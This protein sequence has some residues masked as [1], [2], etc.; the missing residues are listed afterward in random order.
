MLLLA[1][2][3]QSATLQTVHWTESNVSVLNFQA[4]K[5][6]PKTFWK[7]ISDS[8]IHRINFP[9]V[10]AGKVSRKASLE[11]R[12]RPLL[13]KWDC[14]EVTQ[15]VALA[16]VATG[17]WERETMNFGDWKPCF[18]A[19]R[20]AISVDRDSKRG[21]CATS[22]SLDAMSDE[23]LQ[24]MAAK[25][26]KPY[27]Q[28]KEAIVARRIRYEVDCLRAF[29]DADP[30]RK[31]K[32]NFKK[33]LRVLRYLASIYK[34]TGQGFSEIT[35]GDSD[36]NLAVIIFTYRE[37]LKKGEIILTAETLENTPKVRRV[38]LKSLSEIAVPFKSIV[39]EIREEKRR[40][41]LTAEELIADGMND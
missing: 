32:A 23:E 26:R 35:D 20:L 29:R 27:M 33:Q 9:K 34:A 28:A 16:L 25:E 38:E 10:L 8:I 37:Y 1:H 6:Q 41:K 19:A 3:L 36:D 24:Y 12:S 30:S 40:T 7:S 2:T 31:R 17:A 18:R 21:Q 4:R 11:A 14:E 5:A 15:S 39:S 22:N 13:S